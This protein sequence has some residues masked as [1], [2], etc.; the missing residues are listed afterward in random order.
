M[1]EYELSPIFIALL[2]APLLHR[3]N[4]TTGDGQWARNAQGQVK[5]E[6]PAETPRVAGSIDGGNGNDTSLLSWREEE[7]NRET[8]GDGELEQ[9]TEDE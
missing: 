4:N 6:I 3:R 2:P 5:G 9:I 8:P 7:R 1:R